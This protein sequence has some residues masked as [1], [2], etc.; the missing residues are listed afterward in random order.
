M[1]TNPFHD[2]PSSTRRALNRIGI[3][4]RNLERRFLNTGTT[5]GVTTE[6]LY[7]DTT[8]SG[9]VS[10]ANPLVA[11]AKYLITVQGTYS[12]WNEAL[13]NGTPE[14]DAMFPG[15]TAGRSSTQVGVD[16]ECEFANPLD[17]EHPLDH[18]TDFKISLDGAATFAHIEPDDGPHA[19][20]AP[21]H[22]YKYTV[23][24][25]GDVASFRVQDGGTTSDNYGKL[26]ITI[27]ALDQ[28][29]ETGGGGGGGPGGGSPGGS[30]SL[31]PPADTTISNY[32]LR[33]NASGIPAWQAG[34]VDGGSP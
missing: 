9:Y 29:G 15:S 31:V 20:P 4:V 22:L 27:Q 17:H 13:G 11:G 24:G 26:S 7:F 23:I 14:S 16:A 2:E 18:Q 12:Y 5:V 8:S 6:Q 19:T 30:G 21:Q 32:E 34:G 25:Q 33:V 1:P 10:T 28:S 3:R